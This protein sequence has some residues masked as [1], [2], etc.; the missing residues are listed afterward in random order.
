MRSL[1]LFE[2]VERQSGGGPRPGYWNTHT[3]I[4]PSESRIW[5]IKLL[6]FC[7]PS[8][9]RNKL[10]EWQ[11]ATTAW[12]WHRER[13]RCAFFQSHF[14]WKICRW[15]RAGVTVIQPYG[16]THSIPLQL[17]HVR[18]Q[19]GVKWRCVGKKQNAFIVSLRICREIK[20]NNPAWIALN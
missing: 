5:Y 10:Q 3:N 7:V 11:I 2:N 14:L 18:A 19:N 13:R 4:A 16:K 20:K 8:G 9:G 1:V 12:G 15:Q 6:L 17:N